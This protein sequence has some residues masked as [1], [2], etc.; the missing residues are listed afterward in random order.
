MAASFDENVIVTFADRLY[1]RAST[2]VLTHTLLGAALA[3]LLGVA[4]GTGLRMQSSGQNGL[5]VVLALIGAAVG[6]A[7]GNARAFVLRLQAQTAL[8]QLQIERHTRA[9]ATAVVPLAAS[10]APRMP[11]PHPP[12]GMHSS[13]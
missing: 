9:L 4:A 10:M 6:A 12:P 11:P 2:I 5:A 13:W 8:C 3:A 7:T 1:R